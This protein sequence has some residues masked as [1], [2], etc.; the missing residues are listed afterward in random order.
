LSA[1]VSWLDRSKTNR[2]GLNP[3]FLAARI[4]KCGRA[5]DLTP[6]ARSEI[7]KHGGST[8]LL[9]AVEHAI[10]QGEPAAPEPPPPPPTPPPKPTG[11]LTVTCQPVD[12]DVSVAGNSIGST[13]GGTLSRT[14]DVGPVTVSVGKAEYDA[15]RGGDSVTIKDGETA[16]LEFK[17]KPSLAGLEAAGGRMFQRMVEALGGDAGLKASEFVR[18][19]GGTLISSRDGK[20]TTF[21][22][23]AVIVM[24][25][26]ARFGVRRGS[27][28]FEIAQTKEG[29][30]WQK[31]P[32]GSEVDD[33]E[34]P[35]R[36]LPQYQ[37]AQVIG[38]LRSQNFRMV[39]E[40]LT[41]APGEGT[42]LHATAGSERTAITLDPDFRPKEILL[43]SAGLATGRKIV[44]SG[45]VQKDGA[46]Y[47]MSLQVILPGAAGTGFELKF[48]DIEFH[49]SDVNDADFG[50]RKPGKQPKKK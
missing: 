4:S 21:D 2:T 30:E 36:L 23:R 25:D 5:F 44:Y 6:E 18:G 41:P 42:V 8:K 13:A 45:Y 47:P 9:N 49:P 19:T 32:K 16:R 26:K 7:Q 46:S 10:R 11:N 15:D 37:L 29:L 39:A 34:L 31:Q 35:L 20:P 48:L 3:D 1:V 28:S 38:H 50:F 43:E 14:L 33:L 17:L 27:Q 22:I 40:R 12:C 24:P